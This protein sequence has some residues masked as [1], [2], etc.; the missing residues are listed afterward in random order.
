MDIDEEQ[1]KADTKQDMNA[2]DDDVE[3]YTSHDPDSPA[4]SGEAV[5]R[6]LDTLT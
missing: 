1:T 6:S 2:S 3:S 5:S 4:S